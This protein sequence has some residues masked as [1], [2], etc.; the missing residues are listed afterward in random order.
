MLFSNS[1]VFRSFFIM[2]LF[3]YLFSGIKKLLY[4]VDTCLYIGANLVG[5]PN[6]IKDFLGDKQKSCC[7]KGRN[8][9]QIT[10]ISGLPNEAKSTFVFWGL[11]VQW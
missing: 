9:E 8:Q 2:I 1:G 11:H 6:P 5:I 10:K 4:F 3:I 7:R